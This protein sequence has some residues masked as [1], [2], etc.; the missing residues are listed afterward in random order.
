M[1]CTLEYPQLAEDVGL[2]PLGAIGSKLGVA[3]QVVHGG[4]QR[5][6]GGVDRKYAGGAAGQ[7]L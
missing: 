3:C 5:R 2:A 1:T 7:G 4:G 6:P